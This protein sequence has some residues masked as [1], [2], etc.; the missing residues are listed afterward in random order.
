MKFACSGKSGWVDCCF[1]LA[2]VLKFW[3]RIGLNSKNTPQSV[4]M[5]A[6]LVLVGGEAHTANVKLKLP[7][8]V[9][10]GREASLVLRHTLISRQHCEIFEQDGQ[11]MV[12][13]L[14][15]KNGT[16][17]G[18]QP[19][20]DEPVVLADGELLTIGAVTF[21]AVHGETDSASPTPDDI[22]IA[23]PVPGPVASSTDSTVKAPSKLPHAHR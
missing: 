14:N 11:L 23:I 16:F 3:A 2:L 12:R 4:A 6:Q 9:G 1:S 19:I 10:R 17:V 22:P 13:D 20:G 5:D 7:T 21:R 18:N 15:S 8:I